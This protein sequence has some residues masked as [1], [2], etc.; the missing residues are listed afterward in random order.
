MKNRNKLSRWAV[1][2]AASTAAVAMTLSGC[3]VTGTTSS[4][5]EAGSGTGEIN[6]LLMKQ[7]G[8]SED[9]SNQMIADFETANPDIK[10]NATY[11]AY[12]A[13]HDKIV[14]SAPAGTYDVVLMDVIWPS[15]FA[16]SGIVADITERVPA[17]WNDE[18]LGGALIT[19][20]YKD[21]YF[22]IP[23]FPSTKLFFYNNDMVTKAGGSVDDLQTWEG[24]L[25]I[26]SKIKAEGTVEYP[27]VWSWAQAEALIC[28][29]AQI[30]GAFGG[31]F[32][33]ADGELI[34]NDAAGV[35]ALTW[36]RKTIEDGL[37][38]PASTTFLEDDVMK[39]MAAGQ[40]A[41]GLNWEATLNSFNDPSISQ[42]VDQVG[43][44]QSPAG[45]NG[46]RPSV[47]GAMALAI[48]AQ[49]KN[50]DA[51]WKYMEY[52]TSQGVQEQFTASAMPIWKSSFA[53]PAVTAGNPAVFAAAAK[54]FDEGI[55]RPVVRD[56]NQVSSILQVELQNAL[57][58]NK[59]PQQA[60][61]DAVA[62]GNEILAK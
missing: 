54:A 19:A 6:V 20:K 8:F 44:M 60:L 47:N 41:F 46:D 14:T 30:L 37:T 3:S 35:E 7:A 33:N 12:E 53:N 59:S 57:L 11:V 18:I 51:A 2:A 38:N 28:D 16:E 26:A 43:V 61:D 49:S 5:G 36:M 21:K 10:V 40:A 50:Q 55:L 39:T 15:E 23:W 42:V 56:Y 58:G 48:T 9:D 13:L 17:A 1:T 34:I 29:Y 4:T 24:V 52:V 25:D 31:E 62:A 45:P 27:L 22:G 32:T